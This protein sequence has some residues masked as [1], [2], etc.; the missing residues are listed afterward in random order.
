MHL[1]T[2]LPGKTNRFRSPFQPGHQSTPMF[3]SLQC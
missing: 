1:W 2:A 3:E